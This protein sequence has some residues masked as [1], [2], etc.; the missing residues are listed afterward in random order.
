MSDPTAII[1]D[2]GQNYM[3]ILRLSLVL[4]FGLSVFPVSAGGA[5]A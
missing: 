1:R 4:V 5:A 2:N 3:V